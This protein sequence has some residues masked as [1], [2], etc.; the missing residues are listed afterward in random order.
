MVLKSCRD[1]SNYFPVDFH[2]HTRH[3]KDCA[4]DPWDM[5][6]AAEALG[7]Y[8][9]C[10]TEHGSFE[11][12]SWVEALRPHTP[13]KLFRGVEVYTTWSHLQLFGVSDDFWRSW[14]PVE[15]RNGRAY[16]DAPRIAK[17][18]GNRGAIVIVPHPYMTGYT[19]PM[20]EHA[21][22]LENVVAVETRSG[23]GRIRWEDNLRAT[24]LADR[25]QVGHTG[26]SDAH[27]A[28][29]VGTWVTFLPHPAKTLEDLLSLLKKGG[30][31]PGR[32]DG[33][34][35]ENAKSGKV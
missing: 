17:E 14:D 29:D 31:F 18:A 8:G 20:G 33:S 26:G 1:S 22:E 34:D 12:S 3:S 30:Y 9:L 35:S 13:V 23:N 27:R 10:I 25:L 7:L 21:A 28:Q 15:E 32:R 6:K 24:R 11:A 5:V 19:F 2:I 16:Y 4:V